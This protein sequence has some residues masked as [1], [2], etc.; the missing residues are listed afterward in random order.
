MKPKFLPLFLISFLCS[1]EIY[2]HLKI[3]SKH[4]LNNLLL[5][6]VEFKVSCRNSLL[7]RYIIKFTNTFLFLG[8]S[9]EKSIKASN[10]YKSCSVYLI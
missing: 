7:K 5:Y 4:E 9:K 8:K 10:I 3:L 1:S 6:S 2:L